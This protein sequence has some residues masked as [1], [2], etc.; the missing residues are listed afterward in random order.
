MGGHCSQD[1]R[2]S[3]CCIQNN[4]ASTRHVQDNHASTR[5]VQ[6]NHASTRRIQDNRS[7]TCRVQDNRSS[8]R[9]VQDN[10]SSTRRVQDNCSSTRRIQD[11]HAS[12]CV[13]EGCVSLILV[14]MVSVVLRRP[15]ATVTARAIAGACCVDDGCRHV[16]H[17]ELPCSWSTAWRSII[18]KCNIQRIGAHTTSGQALTAPLGISFR[19]SR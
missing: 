17:L 4:H 1:N 3:T 12:G 19:V 8:T 2:A 5:H 7:S 15:R 14:F 18:R 13:I 6:D 9:R 16:M 11:T 10:R